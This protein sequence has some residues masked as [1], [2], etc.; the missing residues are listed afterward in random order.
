MDSA[1]APASI[2]SDHSWV[3]DMLAIGECPLTAQDYVEAYLM[4][5][6]NGI[7]QPTF[8]MIHATS[9]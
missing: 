9:C 2:A 3:P 7:R 6:H 4:D 8:L 5:P 1:F